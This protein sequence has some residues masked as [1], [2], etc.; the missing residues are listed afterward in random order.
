MAYLMRMPS[1][2][3]FDVQWSRTPPRLFWLSSERFLVDVAEIP[4]DWDVSTYKSS[5]AFG[6]F[7]H[8]TNRLEGGFSS[9]FSAKVF[10]FGGHQI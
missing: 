2:P 9:I 5:V 6:R 1:R 7:V 4:L 10:C 8:V 3:K